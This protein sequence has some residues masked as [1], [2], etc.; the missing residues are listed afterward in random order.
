MPRLTLGQCCLS[1]LP[2]VLGVCSADVPSIS[3]AVNAAQERLIYAREARDEGWHGSFSEMAFN[4]LQSDPYIA[5]SRHVGRIMSVDVCDKPIQINN[6]FQEYLRFGNG[7]QPGNCSSGR[8]TCSKVQAYARGV[9][10]TFRDMTAGH[11]IRIRAEDPLDVTGAKRTLIQGTDT[12]DAVITSLDATLRVQ[13]VYVVI[14]APFVDTPMAL[15]TLSGIQKD[16]TNGAIQFWDVDPV[17][18]AEVLILTMEGGETVAGYPRWYFS[19][20]PLSCCQVLLVNG[21]PTVQVKALVKLNLIPVVVPTDYLLIQCMEAIIAEC[22]SM[23]YST[24][25]LPASKEMAAAAHRDAIRLLNG[26]LVHY[27]GTQ[28]PSVSVKPFGSANLERQGIGCL[29]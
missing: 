18:G 15:N 5:G 23:R 14:G 21:V 19:G 11:K 8:V 25:D 7:R 12:S 17:T 29:I 9:F 27:Y 13:G 1:R 6:Q 26:E 2:E 3:N 4:V 20:L 24:I 10:P 16:V 22:Q 28:N